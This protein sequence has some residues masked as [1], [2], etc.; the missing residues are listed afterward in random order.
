MKAGKKVRSGFSKIEKER[1]ATGFQ[2]LDRNLAGGIRHRGITHV[3]GPVKAGKS[4]FI[5][6]VIRQFLDATKALTVLYISPVDDSKVLLRRVDYGLA[7][8]IRKISSIELKLTASW[9]IS[10]F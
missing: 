3:L 6:H 8:L 9:T 2:A 10:I 1:L 4:T 7:S 5:H